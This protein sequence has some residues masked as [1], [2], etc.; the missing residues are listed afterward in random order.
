[1]RRMVRW[2]LGMIAVAL[3][4]LAGAGGASA[5]VTGAADNLRTGWYP[6]E[7]A[8]A[9]SVVGGGHFGK[10]F[11]AELTG[12]IY[13]QPLVANGTLLV[14][15]EDDWIYGIDP[16]TGTKQWERKVG[17]PVN[18]G[19]LPVPCPDLAPHV[20]ITGAPVIDSENGV[21]YFVANELSEGK[22]LWRMHAVELNS[23]KEVQGGVFPVTI[24][25]KA[26][27]LSAEFV[28]TQQ[29]QRPALLM[30]NGVVYAAFGSHCDSDPYQGWIVGVS[31]AGNITT[32]WATSAN[33]ASIWQAGGGLVSD[34]PGRIFFSTGN[35]KGPPGTNDPKPGPGTPP[36][37]GRLGESVVHVEVQPDGSLKARDFFS[38]FNNKLLDEVDIDLGSSGPIALPSQFGTPNVPH[39][40]VQEGK[41]GEVYLLNGDNLGGMG[42]GEDHVV[43][44]LGPYGGVWGV[45]AAWPGDGRYVYVPSVSIPKSSEEVKNSLRFFTYA[46]DESGNPRLSPVA[47]TPEDFWFGS[48]SPIV[49]SNGTAN[50]SGVIWITQCLSKCEGLAELRAYSA[51]PNGVTP[52]PFWSAKVG[53]AT[54]FSRP[55]ASAGHIY[56][57]NHEGRI[58]AFSSPILSPSSEAL[59]LAAPVGGQETRA[60]TITS[61]GTEVE[62]GKVN[63][64]SGPFEASGLPAKGIKLKRGESLTVKV[65]FKPSARGAVNGEFG[66]ITQ[67]G[68]ETRV[69]LSGSGEESAQ[70]KAEREQHEREA[71]ERAERE[72]KERAEREAKERAER[73][74]SEK[75]ASTGAGT[76]VNLLTQA[77]GQGILGAGPLPSLTNLRIRASASRL[78]SHKRRLVVTYTLSAASTVSV[79]IE[80]RVRSHSCQAGTSS[81]LRWVRTKINLKVSGQAGAN[82]LSVNLGTLAAGDYRLAGTPVTAAGQLGVTGYVR[83]RTVH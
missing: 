77:A 61:T 80:H 22:N 69:S 50:A 29:L 68:A 63:P 44:E 2:G 54:K 78:G 12:Q 35:G 25:G 34:G 28:G 66:I 27:N 23:G 40:I 33:G 8:L 73:E 21:A 42:E 51:V 71:K 7:A 76:A 59:A 72:A 74:A 43:Q 1:M 64:P 5:E 3:A 75:T 60:V 30:M 6:D 58:I 10:A 65:T 4:A 18:A 36:P 45:A 26:Q 52:L 49:T 62:V 48:G 41:Y 15:T 70:E 55:V 14:V 17:T 37:E 9:P 67:T 32:K 20:G 39:P 38:P 46:Q 24:Q 57:G 13:A 47:K 79:V 83:F 31:T 82:V 11:E 56:V 53:T 81:C 19:E 16:V